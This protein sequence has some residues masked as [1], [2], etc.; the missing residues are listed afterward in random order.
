MLQEL[1]TQGSEVGQ[2]YLVKF[3]LAHFHYGTIGV[4]DRSQRLGF[5]QLQRYGLRDADADLGINVGIF[6][7]CNLN[8]NLRL[9]FIHHQKTAREA[10]RETFPEKMGHLV[11]RF[12][13]PQEGQCIIHG[14]LHR[15]QLDFRQHSS[16]F[17]RCPISPDFQCVFLVSR[18]FYFVYG[19]PALAHKIDVNNNQPDRTFLL[20][21]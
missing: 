12:P 7:L 1:Q 6:L 10:Q 21:Y 3:H 4:S 20:D 16:D 5:D 18:L 14:F 11:P 15:P 19:H 8:S 17:L 9:N 13:D 2:E